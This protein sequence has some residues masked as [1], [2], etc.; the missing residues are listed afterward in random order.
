MYEVNIPDHPVNDLPN[1]L[2]SAE[3]NIIKTWI[4]WYKV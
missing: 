1:N 3:Q 4:L 2:T